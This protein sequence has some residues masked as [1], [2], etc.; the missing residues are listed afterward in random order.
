MPP[1]IFTIKRQK[2]KVCP[3][4]KIPKMGDRMDTLIIG[5]NSGS[6]WG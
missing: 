4:L 6:V 1:Q 2:V 5:T 3:H